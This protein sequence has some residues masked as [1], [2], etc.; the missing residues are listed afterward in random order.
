MGWYQRRVHGELHRDHLN[1]RMKVFILA[2]VILVTYCNAE[3]I[4]DAMTD[5]EI[6][7]EIEIAARDSADLADELAAML[8]HLEDEE[9]EDEE[10]IS[11]V[12][13]ELERALEATEELSQA[14]KNRKDKT[15]QIRNKN[16]KQRSRKPK[17]DSS[18]IDSLADVLNI[19]FDA[20]FDESGKRKEEAKSDEAE[21]DREGKAAGVAGGAAGGKGHAAQ[22]QENEVCESANP[23]NDVK[24]CVP[25]FETRP[26]RLHFYSQETYD[27]EYCYLKTLTICNILEPPVK[28]DVCTFK[29][30]EKTHNVPAT[31]V[32]V[33]FERHSEK[34]GVTN[35][36]HVKSDYGKVEEI[37]EIQYV[38]QHYKLPVVEEEVLELVSV[39]YPE[40]KE[41]CTGF[42]FAIPET[43]CKEKQDDYCVMC[44]HIKDTKVQVEADQVYPSRHGQCQ[45]VSLALKQD[46]CTI[47][48]KVKVPAPKHGYGAPRAVGYGAPRP[49]YRA[50]AQAY[51]GG[52]SF[53]AFSG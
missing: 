50:P 11:T 15:K 26:Q 1:N 12:A 44:A 33:S 9:E 17:K 52:G 18:F 25:E 5:D 41:A 10:S 46:R 51:G 40:P 42:N 2:L 19:D 4:P 14:S 49:A 48:R 37:C 39:N 29:Y 31:N 16:Q 28:R 30:L 13:L 3:P 8:L 53:T 43:E 20:D 27:E 34:M 24:V 21:K 23:S 7:D 36:K 45:D 47:E 32:Q 38:S 22:K 35:C 6:R